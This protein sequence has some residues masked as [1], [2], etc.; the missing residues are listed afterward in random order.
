MVGRIT[1]SA[2]DNIRAGIT[3]GT[4]FPIVLLIGLFIMAKSKELDIAD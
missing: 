1:Q 2:D 3:V 4:I